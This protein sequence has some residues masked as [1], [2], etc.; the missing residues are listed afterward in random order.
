[1]LRYDLSAL[2]ASETTV[3]QDLRGQVDVLMFFEPDCEWCFRQVR[4]INQMQ[5]ECADLMAVGIGINGSRRNLL[6]ELQR[7]RPEFPAYQISRELQDDIGEIEGTP[8][9]IF[10]DDEGNF[11][12]YTRG[13]QKREV[14]EPLLTELKPDFCNAA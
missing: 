7:M 11:Q 2:S 3:F 9:M 4:L 5:E 13:Y 1:M 8:L 10:V 12:T 14:F 6:A